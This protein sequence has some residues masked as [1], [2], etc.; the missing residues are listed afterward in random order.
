LSAIRVRATPFAGRIVVKDVVK[1]RAELPLSPG[2]R[3][4]ACGHSGEIL[5][6]SAEAARKTP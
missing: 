1:I 3:A 6:D 5:L 4:K 2:A